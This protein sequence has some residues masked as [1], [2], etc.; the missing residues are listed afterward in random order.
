LD[1]DQNDFPD[2]NVRNFVFGDSKAFYKPLENAIADHF[3]WDK[4]HVIA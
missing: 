3:K 1:V 4:N 2:P